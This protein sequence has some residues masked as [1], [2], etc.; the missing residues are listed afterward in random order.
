MALGLVRWPLIMPTQVSSVC[1]ISTSLA[2]TSAF[3]HHL[4]MKHDRKSPLALGV[5]LK[6][7]PPFSATTFELLKQSY[8][9]SAL[10][11]SET[12]VERGKWTCRS[13]V[14]PTVLCISRGIRCKWGIPDIETFCMKPLYL[15]VG[16]AGWDLMRE[17][18]AIRDHPV[19]LRI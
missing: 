5:L 19:I 13:T 18:A 4:G 9:F 8:R 1:T 2:G 12:R 15:S 7:I 3:H 16:K 10:S 17:K 14:I 11:L 6:V